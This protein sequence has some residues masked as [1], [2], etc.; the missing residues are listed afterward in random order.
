MDSRT[1][2]LAAYQR[3]LT[4]WKCRTPKLPI[5]KETERPAL[6]LAVFTDSCC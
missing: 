2:E 1:R 5:L 6:S 4:L 3:F